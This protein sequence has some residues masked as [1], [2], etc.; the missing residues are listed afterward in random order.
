MRVRKAK[1]SGISCS[2]A[3]RR[4]E[5][6]DSQEREYAEGKRL[7][8]DEKKKVIAKERNADLEAQ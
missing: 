6:D 2:R 3:S 5:R 8:K 7:I 1:E 4:Q